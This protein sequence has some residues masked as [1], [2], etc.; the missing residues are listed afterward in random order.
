MEIDIFMNSIWSANQECWLLDD[1]YIIIVVNMIKL[2]P[3]FTH[4]LLTLLNVA[5]FSLRKVGKYTVPDL[6]AYQVKTEALKIGV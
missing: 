3:K 1:T 4:N 2:V 6:P 5:S